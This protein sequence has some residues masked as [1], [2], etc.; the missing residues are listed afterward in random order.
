MADFPR[1]LTEFEQRFGDEAA[2]AEYL[3]AARWPEG[4]A[5]PGCGG[6][7]GWRL[8]GDSELDRLRGQWVDLGRF[9]GGARQSGATRRSVRETLLASGPRLRS[10]CCAW[11]NQTSSNK[12][13]AIDKD[14]SDLVLGLP[15]ANTKRWVSR[16]KAAVVLAIRAGVISREQAYERYG[17]SPEELAVWE[18]AFD[19]HG[20]RGLRITSLQNYQNA[21][22]RNRRGRARPMANGKSARSG[23]GRI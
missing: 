3:A 21:P 18:A 10:D 4:F 5:C 15:P 20:I 23:T 19:R 2:C 13:M 1:S 17:L 16:R 12:P 14:K 9:A 11:G 8:E 7:K 22:L 6:S